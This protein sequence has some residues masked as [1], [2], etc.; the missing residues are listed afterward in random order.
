MSNFY[1]NI[2]IV[3]LFLRISTSLDCHQ[4]NKGLSDFSPSFKILS[5]QLKQLNIDDFLKN[6]EEYLNSDSV[7]TFCLQLS[8]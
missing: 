4:C 1:T 3:S 6:L 2:L 7:E 5:E 8:W